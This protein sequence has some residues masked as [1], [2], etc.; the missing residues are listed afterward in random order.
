[1]KSLMVLALLAG[2]NL[3]DFAIL[4]ATLDT[5]GL[6]QF[7]TKPALSSSMTTVMPTAPSPP[8]MEEELVETE[9]S[10]TLSNVPVFGSKSANR[11]TTTLVASS[12]QPTA[13]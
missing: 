4:P 7:A 11:S 8:S 10:K 2:L 6:A 5:V 1:M 9:C 12:A 3:K 13:Q